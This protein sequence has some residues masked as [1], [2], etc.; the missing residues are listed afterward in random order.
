M[1]FLH[2]LQHILLRD[3]YAP[4]VVSLISAYNFTTTVLLGWGFK[5]RSPVCVRACVRACLCV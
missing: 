3:I 5:P 1:V 4:A 2:A